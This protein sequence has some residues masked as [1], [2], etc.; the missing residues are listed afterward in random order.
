MIVN[1]YGNAVAITKSDTVDLVPKPCDAIW[2][3][4]A[5]DVVVVLENGNTVTFT[6]PNG[7]IIPIRARRVNSTSTTATGM[8]ALY[9]V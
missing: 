6:V 9:A 5:G 3:N 8:I 7:G 2:V 4:S 1:Q